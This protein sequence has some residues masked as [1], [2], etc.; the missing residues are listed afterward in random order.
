MWNLYIDINF[1]S[2]HFFAGYAE[3]IKDENRQLVGVLIVNVELRIIFDQIARIK[4]G[5][6]GYVYLVNESGIGVL[7]EPRRISRS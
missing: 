1:V 3:P 7:L 6:T 2:K 5:Q 4:I